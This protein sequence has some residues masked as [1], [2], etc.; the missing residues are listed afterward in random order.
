MSLTPPALSWLGQATAIPVDQ[1]TLTQLQGS[2]S[3]TLYRV[4]H[5]DKPQHP[6]YVL[7]VL[8][9][10]EWLAEENDLAEH[11][12]AALAQAQGTG[13]NVPKP[14]AYAAHDIGFGAP[15]VL[16]SFLMGRIDLHPTNM[17]QWLRELAE[18]LATIHQQPA[19]DFPWRF[20][21]W[22]NRASL[23]PP[24][25]SKAPQTWVRAIERWR[26]T[27]PN[28]PLVFIHRDYHPTNVLFQDGRV[29]GVV[30]WINA[31]RGPAGVDLAHCKT[32]LVMMY[33]HDIAAQFH[34]AYLKTDPAFVYEPYWDIDSVLDMCLLGP[35]F[36]EPWAHFGL[37]RI[38]GETLQHRIDSYLQQILDTE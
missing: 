26:Q 11:E 10:A 18:A 28:S 19:P 13:Q 2:T 32:N 16:M 17:G 30:D 23:A 9:N 31:C 27:A 7:R 1:L 20:R 36:Y 3:S 6:R 33:G 4:E 37:S 21:S 25:W 14:I 38:S 5:A 34:A 29:S 15:V 24:H 12:F 35:H 8:D 22:V